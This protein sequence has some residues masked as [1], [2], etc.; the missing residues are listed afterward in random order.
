MNVLLTYGG[1]SCTLFTLMALRAILGKFNMSAL[2]GV[3]FS[4]TFGIPVT[5]AVYFLNSFLHFL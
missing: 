1:V 4:F 2:D 5:G 3:M